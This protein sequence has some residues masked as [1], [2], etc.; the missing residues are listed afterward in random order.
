[1][2]AERHVS[3]CAYVVE[4]EIVR[5]Q[6]AGIPIPTALTNLHRALL[7]ELSVDRLRRRWQ[8]EASGSGP[9]IAESAPGPEQ[10]ESTADVAE[11]LG[12][13]DRTVRRR[14]ARQ[15]VPKVGGRYLFGATGTDD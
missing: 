14:A 11:R 6:I 13:T 5:R 3:Q 10:L 2:L 7:D 15:G 4:Q 1:V 8:L 12:V 9:G